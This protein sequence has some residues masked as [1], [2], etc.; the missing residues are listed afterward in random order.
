MTLYCAV[1]LLAREGDAYP[2]QTVINGQAV[3]ADHVGY[4]DGGEL[5]LIIAQ[6]QKDIAIAKAR[7]DKST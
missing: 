4:A 5:D 6:A 7:Q 1:C 2:A 3:C